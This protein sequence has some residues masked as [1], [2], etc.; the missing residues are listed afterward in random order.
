MAW[1]E[2]AQTRDPRHGRRMRIIDLRVHRVRGEGGML[3][4]EGKQAAGLP[5]TDT[6]EV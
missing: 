4:R 5:T 6:W 1:R 2:I 3:C